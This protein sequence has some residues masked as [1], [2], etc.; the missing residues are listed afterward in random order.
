MTDEPR[1][2]PD[3]KRRPATPKELKAL[4]TLAS[5]LNG[6]GPEALKKALAAGELVE[7]EAGADGVE[8]EAES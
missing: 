5:L 3:A 4:K 1:S 7:L 2:D 8:G 6:L